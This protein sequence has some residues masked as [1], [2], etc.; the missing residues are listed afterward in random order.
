M[1]LF[2][3]HLTHVHP[4]L[5]DH[6]LVLRSHTRVAALFLLF[7][8]PHLAVVEAVVTA[9]RVPVEGVAASFGEYTSRMREQLPVQRGY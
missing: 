1:H 4:S 8:R 7:L 3:K 5:H 2:L 9:D 6:L